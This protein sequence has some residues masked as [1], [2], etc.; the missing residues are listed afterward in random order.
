[1]PRDY[2]YR[3]A[4]KKQKKPAPAWLWMLVGLVLG[5][6][7]TWLVWLKQDA[8]PDD[9]DWVGAKPDRQP[10]RV[11]KERAPAQVPPHKPRFEFFDELREKEVLVPEEQLDLRS[12]TADE[13]ARYELQI[14]SFTR[15]A[16]AERLKAQ[17]ALLGVETRV[18][19]A[20]IDTGVRYR[21][22]AGP[23]LGR[24]ALDKVR[25]LLRQNGHQGLLVR[26]VR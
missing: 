25:S 19:E 15:T 1:M 5:G 11:E 12:N 3:A 2:K 4:Q 23:Y 10:Q 6:F 14:G 21:V 17:L 20:R 9:Q 18:S 16:D 7:V 13:T 8:A 24:S 26:V 22:I